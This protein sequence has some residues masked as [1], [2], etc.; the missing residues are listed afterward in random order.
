VKFYFLGSGLPAVSLAEA[1]NALHP[2]SVLIG[3]TR[4]QLDDENT[5]ETYVHEFRQNLRVPT[6]ILLGGNLKGVQKADLDRQKLQYFPTLQ[7]LD[8]FL[9]KKFRS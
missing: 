8:E 4:F 6:N 2:S 9:A 1:T 3:T 7:A 5:V